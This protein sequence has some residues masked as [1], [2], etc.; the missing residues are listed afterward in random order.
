MRTLNRV[1]AERQRDR[2]LQGANPAT[3]KIPGWREGK[4]RWTALGTKPVLVHGKKRG[5]KSSIYFKARLGYA[6]LK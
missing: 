2:R 3:I 1:R 5:Q 6:L 4:A